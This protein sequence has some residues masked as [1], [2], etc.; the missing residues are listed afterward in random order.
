MTTTEVVV[1]RTELSDQEFVE[2]FAKDA[3]DSGIGFKFVD[4]TGAAVEAKGFCFRLKIGEELIVTN[5]H[6][7]NFRIR[8]VDN[9]RATNRASYA[10]SVEG[11]GASRAIVLM[12][13]Q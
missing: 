9:I 7:R 6:N 11:D 8:Y 10:L 3:F 1:Q 2:K 5:T 12:V 13:N 4:E